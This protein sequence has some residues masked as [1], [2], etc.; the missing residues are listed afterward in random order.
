MICTNDQQQSVMYTYMYTTSM[1]SN[2]MPEQ[3]A[4]EHGISCF[5]RD[6]C[7]SSLRVRVRR[8][9]TRWIR[10]ESRDEDMNGGTRGQWMKHKN[11][12]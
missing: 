7:V 6:V 11:K 4:T 8:A 5:A 2:T 9:A 3:N 12:T 10:R 1:K